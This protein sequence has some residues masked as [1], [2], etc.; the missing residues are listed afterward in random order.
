MYYFQYVNCSIDT[1]ENSWSNSMIEGIL[2]QSFLKSPELFQG[3]RWKS[4]GGGNYAD[5]TS[6]INPL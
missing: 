5:W 3:S 2:F 6:T 4:V 1:I